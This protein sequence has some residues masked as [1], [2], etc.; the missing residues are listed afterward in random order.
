MSNYIKTIKKRI[1]DFERKRILKPVTTYYFSPSNSEDWYDFD[2]INEPEDIY[3]PKKKAKIMFHPRDY[4][5]YASVSCVEP[6]PARIGFGDIDRIKSKLHK[7]QNRQ[8]PKNEPNVIILH[9]APM[10]DALCALYGKLQLT[11]FKNSKTGVIIDEYINRDISG[12]FQSSTRVSAVVSV[13]YGEDHEFMRKV[14]LNPKARNPLRE[15]EIK[16]IEG[17]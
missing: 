14:F 1:V 2:G 6:G 13:G 9:N 7:K 8:L 10:F 11:I 16:I 15:E 3:D 4:L 12:I 17:M 5:D